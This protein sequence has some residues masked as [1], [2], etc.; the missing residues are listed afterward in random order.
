MITPEKFDVKIQFSA[1][2]IAEMDDID[3]TRFFEEDFWGA[4]ML[5]FQ[6]LRGT[7]VGGVGNQNLAQTLDSVYAVE[8]CRLEFARAHSSLVVSE[9]GMVELTFSHENNESLFAVFNDAGQ[10]LHLRWSIENHILRNFFT[11]LLYLLSF[12]DDELIQTPM[13]QLWLGIKK[14][15]SDDDNIVIVQ[16]RPVSH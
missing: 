5:R 11:A 6:H 12:E 2:L 13:A 4:V 9:D 3:R 8:N 15:L 7:A 14:S 10:R 16:E 1:P